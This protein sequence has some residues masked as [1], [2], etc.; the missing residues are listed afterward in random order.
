MGSLDP[1]MSL[2][3]LI[4]VIAPAPIMAAIGKRDDLVFV[5]WGVIVAAMAAAVENG[6]DAALKSVHMSLPPGV[7]PFLIYGLIEESVKFAALRTARYP[8]PEGRALLRAALVCALGFACAE[9]AL[10]VVG[11]AHKLSGLNLATASLVRLFLPLTFHLVAA[12]L[13]VSGYIVRGFKPLGGLALAALA[14][15]CYDFFLSDPGGSGVRAAYL[16]IVVCFFASAAISRR[17]TSL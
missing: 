15:G 9:N 6:T 17:A 12:P 11:F 1:G 16:T 14:H 3:M 5:V 4:V 2:W 10:Y 7:R 13:L 8:A